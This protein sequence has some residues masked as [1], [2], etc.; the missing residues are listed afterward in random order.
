MNTRGESN[1]CFSAILKKRINRLFHEFILVIVIGP[2]LSP[3]FAQQVSPDRRDTH[4]ARP[5]RRI[6][7][8]VAWLS[9][10]NGY[11]LCPACG[12]FTRSSRTCHFRA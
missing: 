3:A 9:R 7:E 11:D 4:A 10:P 6:A 5:D 1:R 12:R 8:T 2:V